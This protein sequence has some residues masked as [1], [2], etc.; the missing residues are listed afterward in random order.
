MKQ[1][2]CG[3]I[4]TNPAFKYLQVAKHERYALGD[5]DYFLGAIFL[6]TNGYL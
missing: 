3:E 4:C 2:S 6:L 5:I 1:Q